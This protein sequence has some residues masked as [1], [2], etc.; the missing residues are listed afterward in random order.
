MVLDRTARVRGKSIDAWIEAWWHWTFAVPAD[1]NPELVLDAS[2]AEG[3]TDQVFFVPAYDGAST[4]VR[5]C[6]VQPGTPVLVPLWVVINDYPCPD[7]T[8]EPAP[9]QSLEDFLREGAVGFNDHLQDLQVSVDDHSVDPA[10]HRHTTGMFEFSAEPSLVG[11]LP[12]ACLQGRPQPGV[13]D[14]WWLMLRLR[15]GLHVVRVTATTPFGT[16]IDYT[17]RLEVGHE[18]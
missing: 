10:S 17:Y 6:R 13:S 18:G 1:R 14:G 7:P 15:P 5:T 12:D 2:C 16:P 3:Q 9:G 4:Y 8:F 11:Q